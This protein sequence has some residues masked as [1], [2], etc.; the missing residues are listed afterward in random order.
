MATTAGYEVTLLT[1]PALQS[2]VDILAFTTFGDPTKDAVFKSA[3]QALGGHLAEVAKH[4]S[5]DGKTGQVLTMYT[6]GKLP[7][8]RVVVVGAGN[9]TDFATPNLRDV[10]AAVAQTANKVGAHTVGFVVPTLGAGREVLL[11]Q[12]AVEGLYLGSYKFSRYLTGE[13]HKKPQALK[14]FGLLTD[15]KGKKP[16]AAQTKTLQA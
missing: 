7:A 2:Q 3:D 12:M 4:E 10:T 1:G 14:T 8:K 13:D 6:Q 11:V 5:F 15:V 16:T 9:R